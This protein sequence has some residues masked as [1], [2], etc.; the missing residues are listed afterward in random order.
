MG[1]VYE[2]DDIEL[3]QPVALKALRP[4][5]RAADSAVRFKREIL[6]ARKVTHPN[7]CRVFD[8][9]R[10]SKDGADIDFFTMELVEGE[11]LAALLDR[12][13]PLSIEE[14]RPLMEQMAA[15]LAALH[16]RQ[17]VHRDLK[18]GNI[19]LERRPNGRLRVVLTDFGIAGTTAA[20][21]FGSFAT[22][23]GQVMGT[24]E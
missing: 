10:Y 14:A 20:G 1:E 3:G 9:G 18:P 4:R 24:P 17:I 23:S 11:T 8:L 5:T 6:L 15:G 22:L 7:V 21:A 2:C 12:E 16:D 13:G 19:L